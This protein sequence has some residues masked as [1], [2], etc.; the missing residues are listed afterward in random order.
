MPGNI[1]AVDTGFPELNQ[2]SPEEKISALAGYVYQL[3]EQ[4]RYTLNNLGQDNFND[5]ELKG[6]EKLFTGPLTVRVEETEKGMAK[7]EI[8]AEGITATVQ[9]LRGDLSSIRQTVE[10]LQICTK[11][12]DDVGI[13]ALSGMSLYFLDETGDNI[14]GRVNMDNNGSGVDESTVRMFVGTGTDYAGRPY[15]LKLESAGNTSYEGKKSVF[16]KATEGSVNING[17]NFVRLSAGTGNNKFEVKSDRVLFRDQALV[18]ADE[19]KSIIDARLKAHR[20]IS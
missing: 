9:N 11:T 17:K 8:T 1:L 2:G 16:I 6:L 15:S 13:S 4:L 7:L 18:T 10:G 5:T 19:V 14:I 3:L 12:E 20:L